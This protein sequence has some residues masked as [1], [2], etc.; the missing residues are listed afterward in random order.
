MAVYVPPA[1]SVGVLTLGK[2]IK[3]SATLD[4]L[5]RLLNTVRGTDKVLMFVQYF[6]K[7]LVWFAQKKQRRPIPVD[8]A[9]PALDLAQHLRNLSSPVSDFRILLRYYGLLPMLQYMSSVERTASPSKW[10]L[11]LIRLQNLSMLLYY[12]MEHIYWLGA[13]RIIPLSEQKS[14]K[15]AMWSCRFWAAY[16]VLEFARLAEEWRLLKVKEVTIQKKIKR[17]LLQTDKG[18][19]KEKVLG[20]L[21]AA[22]M[23][24][25]IGTIVN[26]AY[27]PLTVHWSL[28]QSSFPDV[29]VGVCG[30]LAAIG[31]LMTAWWDTA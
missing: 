15:I 16:V 3:P 26:A 21:E 17:D 23:R 14:N 29:A 28:E 9:A 24:T 12:P 5:V 2:V 11:D 10:H 22:K 19:T 30:T 7:I 8:K 31:Q 13:H 25:K 6:C 27:L 20:E 18:E 1:S 4:H